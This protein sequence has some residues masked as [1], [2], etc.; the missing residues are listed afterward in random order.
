M[1]KCSLIAVIQGF[2]QDFIVGGGEISHKSIDTTDY[3]IMYEILGVFLK[4][5]IGI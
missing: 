5:A 2:I 3:N 1:S 4:K